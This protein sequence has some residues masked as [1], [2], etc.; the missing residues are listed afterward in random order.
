MTCVCAERFEDNARQVQQEMPHCSDC[1]GIVRPHRPE[2]GNRRSGQLGVKTLRP[3]SVWTR[4]LPVGAFT[5][6]RA[7]EPR[8]SFPIRAQTKRNS[9]C[10]SIRRQAPKIVQSPSF[11]RGPGRRLRQEP[12][13]ARCGRQARNAHRQGRSGAAACVSRRVQSGLL[14]RRAPLQL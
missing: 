1:C 12:L 8:P 14:S 6:F 5:A 3:G 10:T 13:P 7:A 9:A 11:A 4:F 2:P